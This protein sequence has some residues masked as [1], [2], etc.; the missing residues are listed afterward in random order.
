[1][2][3]RLAANP[4]D[5]PPARIRDS[6]RV[7]TAAQRLD[8]DEATIRRLVDDGTL[9]AHRI[10][11]RGV[12]IYSDAIDAYQAAQ[13]IVPKSRRAAAAPAPAPARLGASYHEAVAFLRKHGVA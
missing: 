12:R 10:G 4:D 13:R 9:E 1:M 7:R 8:C 11:K 3:I 2:T 6:V 5:A